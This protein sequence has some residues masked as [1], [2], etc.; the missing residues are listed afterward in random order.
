MH[1]TTRNR[2]EL[3]RKSM[4]CKTTHLRSFV[5]FLGERAR[6]W[7]GDLFFCLGGSQF[8][9]N[10]EVGSKMGIGIKPYKPWI[11]LILFWCFV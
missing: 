3:G 4:I 7:K 1:F 6:S 11:F 10:V 8:H 5:F 2:W 9:S